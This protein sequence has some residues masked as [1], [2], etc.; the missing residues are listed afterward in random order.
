M[1]IEASGADL[2]S[3]SGIFRVDEWMVREGG[4]SKGERVQVRD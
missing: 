4:Q 3:R 2:R 1:C